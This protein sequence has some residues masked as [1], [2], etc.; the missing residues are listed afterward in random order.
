VADMLKEKREKQWLKKFE[1][2]AKQDLIESI[3]NEY[4]NQ[5]ADHGKK[6]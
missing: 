5:F 3:K 6:V 1:E 4:Q 2:K